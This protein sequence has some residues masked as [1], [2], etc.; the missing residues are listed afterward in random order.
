MNDMGNCEMHVSQIKCLTNYH[1]IQSKYSKIYESINTF[2]SVV[3]SLWKEAL[4]P[5]QDN[6][7]YENNNIFQYVSVKVESSYL[8]NRYLL[9]TPR[10]NSLRDKTCSWGVAITTHYCVKSTPTCYLITLY[11]I[12]IRRKLYSFQHSVE[13]WL[14]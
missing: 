3:G 1:K 2:Y 12:N 6:I 13:L 5:W 11:R 9:P 14:K 4:T 7:F 8:D 10:Y